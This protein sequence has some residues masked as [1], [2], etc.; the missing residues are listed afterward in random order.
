MWI[1]LALGLACQPPEP[2]PVHQTAARAAE[3]AAQGQLT[4]APERTAFDW[5]PTVWAYGLHVYAEQ[6]A[7]PAPVA[8]RDAWLGHPMR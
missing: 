4:W 2:Q 6:S 8:W 1:V 5:I 7:D 3:F